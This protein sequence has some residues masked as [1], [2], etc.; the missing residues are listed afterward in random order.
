MIAAE[1]SSPS[2]LAWQPHP[3]VWVLL[4]GLLT[5]GF[6]ATRV[7][8]PKIE[9]RGGT[10]VLA[11][12]KRWFAFGMIVL[13]IAADWP[14]HD[15]AEEYLYSIHMAQHIL[16]AFIVP[17]AFLMAT[18]RWL[19]D[20]ILGEGRLRAAVYRLARPIPAA[21]I[22]NALQLFTHWQVTVN[23]SVSNALVH[24]ALHTAVVATALLLWMPVCGP[25]TELRVSLP[26]QMVYLFLTSIIPT[27][28]AAW[29]TFAEGVV[30]SA[31]DTP[32]RM[33]G[34]SVTSDQQAAGAIM[35]LGG[36]TFLWVIITMLFFRWAKRHQ[37][38]DRAGRVMVSERDILTWDDVESA[39]DVAG[40]APRE[41]V[42]AV[43]PAHPSPP[44]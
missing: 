16:L 39:F 18:P 44:E 37:R 1:S 30:Y 22:F 17:P 14:V 11:S 2:W 41:V 12:H 32:V 31:Y 10:G 27:V 9:A 3:E 35:K 40:P 34:V 21:V 4:V 15:L 5:L 33:W 13:W 25:I 42:P 38:A 29:L 23:T 6:Y 43:P 36:G 19:V 24:Y 28:P 26:T 8:G 20:L 7:I